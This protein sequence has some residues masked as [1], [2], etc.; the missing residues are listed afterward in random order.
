MELYQYS[1][2]KLR[3]FAEDIDHAFAQRFG[4]SSYRYWGFKLFH[5]Q[6]KKWRLLDG[7]IQ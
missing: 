7:V 5:R 2:Q 6:I 3:D 4:G 1:S